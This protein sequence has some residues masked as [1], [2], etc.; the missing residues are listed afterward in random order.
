V[1]ERR[2]TPRRLGERQKRPSTPSFQGEERKKNKQLWGRKEDHAT[3]NNGETPPS[4]TCQRGR[5]KNTR[6]TVFYSIRRIDSPDQKRSKLCQQE[7]KG[8]KNHGARAAS[9]T[10]IFQKRGGKLNS[11]KRKQI[12]EL[13]IRGLPRDSQK[14]TSRR[15][16]KT[17]KKNLTT[18]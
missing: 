17:R 12:R 4:S 3:K 13:K 1:A 16:V 14:A 5:L 8:G 6:T 2:L 15:P 9:V 7:K 18:E 10:Y 11:K